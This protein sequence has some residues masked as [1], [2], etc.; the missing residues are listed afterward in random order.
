CLCRVR[1]LR[2][3]CL[4]LCPGHRRSF[5]GLEAAA[6][7]TGREDR[8]QPSRAALDGAPARRRPGARCRKARRMSP[9][10]RMPPPLIAGPQG[11]LIDGLRAL[12]GLFPYLW[13]RDSLELRLRVVAA[14]ALLAGAKLIN[15]TTPFFYKATVDALSAKTA[16]VGIIAVPVMLILGYGAARV[17]ALSFNELRNAVFAKVEQRAVRRVALSAFTH[18]HSLSL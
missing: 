11:R 14:L 8:L 10:G 18:L 13:P 12:K 4:R 16:A 2:S 6:A 1:P 7:R 15:I 3:V 9:R 5:G 17:F